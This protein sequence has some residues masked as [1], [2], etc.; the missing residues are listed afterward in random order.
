MA[1]SSR[2]QNRDDPSAT[3]FFGVETEYPIVALDA[4]RERLDPGGSVRTLM[5][6]VKDLVPHLRRV[7]DYDVFTAN[8]SRVYVDVGFHP[9]VAS[10]E[11]STPEEAVLFTRAGD[12]LLARAARAME[13]ASARRGKKVE[14]VIWKANVDHHSKA[15]WGSHESYLHEAPQTLFAEHLISHLITRIIY[16]GAGGFDNRAPA[17]RFVVSP[18]AC[19]LERTISASSTCKRG[20]FHTRDEPL[21]AGRHRRLHVLAGESLWSETADYLRIGTTALLVAQID[22]GRRPQT[23]LYLESPMEAL[24]TINADT[25]CAVTVK[26]R[27]SKSLTAVAIQRRLLESVEADLGAK[28]LPSWAP[29]VCERWRDVLDGLEAS[30]SSLAGVL[31]WPTKLAVLERQCTGE[32]LEWTFSEEPESD[33]PRNASTARPQLGSAMAVAARLLETDLRFTRLD[34]SGIFAALDREGALAHRIVSPDAIERAVH[35]PPCTGR[36]RIR[37]AY[38]GRL[39]SKS[40]AISCNWDR[41]IDH[42]N[43]KMLDLGDPFQSE[44]EQ[45]IPLRADTSGFSQTVDPVVAPI[46]VAVSA[47]APR[48]ALRQMR[49]LLAGPEPLSPSACH[50]CAGVI[51][52]LVPLVP[53]PVL[54]RGGATASPVLAALFE[55]AASRR[56]DSLNQRVGILLYRDHEAHGRYDRACEVI[57]RLLVPARV[58][59]DRSDVAVFTNNLGYDHMLAG[60]NETAEEH[61]A[62]AIALFEQCGRESDVVN[63]RANLLECRFA[64]TQ[65]ERWD[66]LLPM[67]RDLNCSLMANRDWRARKT[68][69]LLARFAEHR[70]RRF[71]ARG[72]ARRAIAVTQ[73]V[74]TQLRKWDRAYLKALEASSP[75]VE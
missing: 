26:L 57:E 5:G 65:P 33:R 10:P 2:A 60:R 18:R 9:E 4:D 37:S 8:G 73:G 45:W 21:A 72:W 3:R 17:L 59:E 75:P 48:E 1:E 25:S 54:R 11:C 28:H 7:G 62:R 27:S 36:A 14:V 43:K 63:T 6:T 12:R 70:G 20:V 31:D 58:E 61:F 29:L 64:R 52:R 55:C 38:V 68:M 22:A 47:R 69:R 50:Y 46:A 66:T 44:A 15:T 32:G 39:A 42:E 41:I 16:T 34:D 13:R 35:E 19:H 74:P 24:A 56:D 40:S 67:L 51:E 30:P 49:A 23:D 53:V 71:A